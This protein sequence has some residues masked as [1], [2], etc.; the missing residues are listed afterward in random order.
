MADQFREFARFL[1]LD[2]KTWND[3]VLVG[4][5]FLVRNGEEMAVFRLSLRCTASEPPNERAASSRP[6]HAS[7]PGNQERGRL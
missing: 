3:P 2:G 4:D 6:S 5:V 7:T 1:V